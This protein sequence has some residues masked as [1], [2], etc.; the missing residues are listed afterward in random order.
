[1]PKLLRVLATASPAGW[2]NCPAGRVCLFS[3]PSGGG[4]VWYALRCGK[5]NLH[6][7]G[8]GNWATSYWSRTG[9]RIDMYEWGSLTREVYSGQGN[10]PFNK[11]KVYDEME[12]IC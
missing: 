11:T 7:F 6:D 5:H 12:I 9:Q 4:A 8:V 10:F 3:P 2:N 1:M